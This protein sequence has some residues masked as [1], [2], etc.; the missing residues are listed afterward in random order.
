MRN[1]TIALLTAAVAFAGAGY[2]AAQQKPAAGK[3]AANA[4]IVYKSPT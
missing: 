4:V 1:K 3:T 2:V